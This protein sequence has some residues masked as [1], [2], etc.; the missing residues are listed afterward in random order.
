MTLIFALLLLLPSCNNEE[1]FVIEESAI[2]EEIPSEEEGTEEETPNTE[3]EVPVVPVDVVDDNFITTE[4]I[5][6]E[7]VL[8]TNDTSLPTSGTIATTEPSNGLLQVNN[9]GTPDNQLDDLV[10]YTPNPSFSGIDSFEYTICDTQNIDNCDT[11]IVSI[12]VEPRE[13]DFA[14]ELKAFPSAY[15]AGAYTTGGR[16][17]VV[18]HVTKLDWDDTPGSLKWALE[19]NYPRII[20]FDVSG[21]ITI[22]NDGT[23]YTGA[24]GNVTIAGQTAP[25]GGI[26]IYGEPLR[27]YQQDNVIIRYIKFRK[28]G[29]S[30]YWDWCLLITQSSDVVVDHCSFAYSEE[31]AMEAGTI[32]NDGN[33]TYQNNLFTECKDAILIGSS[34]NTNIQMGGFSILNNVYVNTG[35]RAPAKIGGACT[36]DMINNAVHNWFAKTINNDGTDWKLNL[37]GNYFQTGAQTLGQDASWGGHTLFR[38][39]TNTIMSPEVWDEDTVFTVYNEG[40]SNEYDPAPAGYPADISLVWQPMPHSSSYPVKSEWFRTSRLPLLGATPNI[41]PS[42]QVLSAVLPN[43]GA[44]KYLNADGT[45]ITYRDPIDTDAIYN[46]ENEVSKSYSANWINIANNGL[47]TMPTNIRP[48]GYDTDNDG[49]PDIWENATFGDLTKGSNGDEDGDGY[50]NIEEFF[51]QVDK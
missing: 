17:G 51:N 4:N 45:A 29:E 42:S 3:D 31:M 14:T 34:S 20:V 33:I 22:P 8:H 47:P 24:K 32:Y 26:T 18:L 19:E 1:V 46:F 35:W 39:T 49:M 36:V 10:I 37:I 16:G 21:I 15:G 40:G 25:E 27:F 30:S 12:T 7:M 43:A 23:I 13:N 50:T 41:L 28:P 38:M 11:A 2:V 5:P 9:N 6:I 44:N 48:A